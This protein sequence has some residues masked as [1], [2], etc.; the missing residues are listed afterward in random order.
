MKSIVWFCTDFGLGSG[1]HRTIFQN[2]NYLV[3]NGY[4][5][6]LYV[7]GK[8]DDET[9]EQVKERIERDFFAL[10][11]DV[12]TGE[13]LHKK[14]DVAIATFHTTVKTVEELDV[15]KKMY[16]I[17]DYE[18]WFFPMGENYLEAQ[19]SYGYGLDGISIGRWLANKIRVEFGA[20]MRYF[21]FCADQNIYKRDENVDKENAVCF[22]YQPDKPRRCAEMGLRALQIVKKER[23]DTKIYLYGSK[24]MVSFNLEAEHLG[25]LSTE[26]CNDLYNKC[27][28]GLCMSSSNPSRVPFEMMAAGLPVVDL[29][30]ENNLYDFPD[31]GCVLAD[32]SA[33]AVAKAIIGILDNDELR[34]TLSDG[35]VQYMK[36]FPLEK[37]FNEFGKAVKDCISGKKYSE[38]KCGKS[39][40]KKA[41]KPMKVDYALPRVYFRTEEEIEKEKED[42]RRKEEDEEWRRN[43][44][45]PQRIYLKARYLIFKR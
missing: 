17:Q 13:M 19:K 33:E 18:P 22:I 7:I 25:L 31:E 40:K 20:K 32:P 45:I 30:L 37:G 28:V 16:F 3:E 23:P 29:Y 35:G 21:S 42:L 9:G 26:G 4:K 27:K 5:C 34:K 6:D 15:P 24:K 8:I 14:Y 11:G 10:K 43:L 39:Y 1:G 2:M 12:Y 41:V 44:T 38:N 36:D